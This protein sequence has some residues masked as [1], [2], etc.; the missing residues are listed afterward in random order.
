MPKLIWLLFT[1][2][3]ISQL[4]SLTCNYAYIRIEQVQGP[5]FTQKVILMTPQ[6]AWGWVSVR[7]SVL[8]ARGINSVFCINDNNKC[9]FPG[10]LQTAALLHSIEK[11][12]FN[13]PLG[14]HSMQQE[15]P[16]LS[17]GG[18]SSKFSA[19]GKFLKWGSNSVL[20]GQKCKALTTQSFIR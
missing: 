20:E 2:I 4:S 18:S 14:S 12:I 13:W 5:T 3:K 10:A 16:I 6:K 11:R 15:L 19:L 8:T 7:L 9:V 17:K 1:K